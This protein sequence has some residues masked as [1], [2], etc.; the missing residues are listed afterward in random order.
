LFR[1]FDLERRW[2]QSCDRRPD[3][4]PAARGASF[5]DGEGGVIEQVRLGASGL[6]GVTAPLVGATRPTHIDD[7]IAAATLE[8]APSDVERLEAPRA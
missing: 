8:L 1:S 7:A 6:P 4:H 3:A 5:P 2:Q